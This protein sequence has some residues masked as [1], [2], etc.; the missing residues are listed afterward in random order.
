MKN[1]NLSP[2]HETTLQKHFFSLISP[3]V[4]LAAF[5]STICLTNAESTSEPIYDIPH[6]KTVRL[7]DPP[8]ILT[9]RG[10]SIE[11]FICDTALPPD[12]ASSHAAA[13]LAWDDAGLL[14]VLTVRDTTPSEA[15]YASAGYTRDSVE[16][17]L[18]PD[19]T[20]YEYLQ[21]VISPGRDP[22]RGGKPRIYYFDV[23][24][25]AKKA[26][27]AECDF[28]VHTNAAGYTVT[29]RL[30]WV[31]LG[32]KPADGLVVGTRIY[33]NDYDGKAKHRFSWEPNGQLFYPVRLAATASP[34]LRSAAW[35]ALDLAT[36]TGRVN[37]TGPSEWA[38]K[39][40]RVSRAGITLG[41]ITLKP[42]A[43]GSAGSL[44]FELSGS[45]TNAGSSLQIITPEGLSLEV[46][47]RLDAERK[48]A[49]ASANGYW[50]ITAN[51]RRK[52]AFAVGAFSQYVF[53]GKDFPEFAFGDSQRLRLLLGADPQVSMTWFDANS[54]P[55][56]R[57][58]N[59]GL[60]GC[61]VEIILP[62]GETFSQNHTFFA[63][64]DGAER[65]ENDDE[66]QAQILAFHLMGADATRGNAERTANRWWHET[67]QRAG[68]ITPYPYQVRLP[69]SYRTDVTKKFPLLVYLHGSG[70]G[71]P[72]ADNEFYEQFIKPRSEFEAV[73]AYPSSH[74]GWSP[75]LVEDMID[76]I[77]KSNR[78][79]E[80]RIYLVGFSMGAMGGW[81]TLLDRP[82]RF[83]AAAI[84]AGGSGCS[85]GCRSVACP[86]HP[87]HQ[88]G[89]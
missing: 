62:W 38:G 69:E 79:D 22:S 49:F 36:L 4:F 65:V 43:A 45:P 41:E 16:I 31:C 21:A 78:I 1:N 28:F 63:L 3:V 48:S 72:G 60:Y 86:A 50:E 14:F 64:P 26:V 27:L 11:R 12:A 19:P 52:A 51:D 54:L 39:Q 32:I 59:P 80:S 33:V 47:N 56:Q 76:E 53:S 70:Y 57:V 83:A 46:P 20:R 5:M 42:D 87:R 84:I 61:H 81:Q 10:F 82:D 67:L 44:R 25:E 2:I 29:A 23:R 24:A 15:R 88:W 73:V 75:T 34:P 68:K 37:L 77:I 6:L 89:H 18:A 8:D 7:D 40:F 17:F 30:P 85:G 9:R 71:R 35:S 66:Q 13:R 58:T 55:V 74:G